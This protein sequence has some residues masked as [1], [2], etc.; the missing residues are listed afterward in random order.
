MSQFDN[1]SDE[2]KRQLI[3]VGQVKESE[4]FPPAPVKPLKAAPS[5]EVSTDKTENEGE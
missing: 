5:V 2:N 3:L 4:L 1:L